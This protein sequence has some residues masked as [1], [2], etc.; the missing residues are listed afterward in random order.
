MLN[1]C[2]T[3]I[4]QTAHHVSVFFNFLETI[5]IKGLRHR[6][7]LIFDLLHLIVEFF[8]V[9]FFQS[10]LNRPENSSEGLTIEFKELALRRLYA[11][12][13]GSLFVVDQ[14]KFTEMFAIL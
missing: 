5:L 14:G 2:I 6:A 11:N 13:E 3:R 8:T 12:A 9:I 4:I 7:L 1:N 10:V